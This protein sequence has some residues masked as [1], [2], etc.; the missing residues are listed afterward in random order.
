ME[1]VLDNGPWNFE[2]TLV[3]A[4]PRIGEN[5]GTDN[6]ITRE[7]FWLHLT[8]LSQYFYT[9]DVGIQ[10]ARDYYHAIYCNCERTNCKGQ[11]FPGFGL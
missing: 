7:Y 3:L 8:S 9:M 10:L 5:I 4:R 11:I 1:F 2:N 6:C